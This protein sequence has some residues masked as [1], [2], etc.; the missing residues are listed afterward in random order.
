MITNYPD[1]DLLNHAVLVY[2]YRD[3]AGV[4]E[5]LAYD[6]N[7]PGSPFGLFFDRTASGF[8]VPP[9]TYSPPGRIRAFRLYTSVLF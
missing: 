6:P 3:E 2:G 9:L 5:F 7:D 8:S 4:S 1:A